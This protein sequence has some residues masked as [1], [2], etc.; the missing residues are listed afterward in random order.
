MKTYH[1]NG[2]ISEVKYIFEENSPFAIQEDLN[3]FFYPGDTLIRKL[4]LELVNLSDKFVRLFF[5]DRKLY[6]IELLTLPIGLMLGGQD[7]DVAINKDEFLNLA[8]HVL[9]HCDN[10]YKHIYIMD[11]QYLISTVQNLLQSAEYCYLQYYI[12]IAQIDCIH[13]EEKEIL[14]TSSPESM[15]L[16]FYLETFFIKL[17]SILDIIVKII[18]ELEN[19]VEVFDTITKLNSS[20]KLWGDRKKL[21]ISKQVDTIFEKCETVRIIESLRNEA[22]HNGTW[23]F[24][25][26]VFIKFKEK[27]IVE[28]YMLFPDI[29]DGRLASV[30]NRKHFFSTEKKVNDMLVLIHDDFYKRLLVTLQYINRNTNCGDRQEIT[31]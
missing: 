24:R 14:T 25:P 3:H 29:I 31:S 7:S 23:E 26:K 2:T 8:K 11:C 16:M 17:Y 28:R 5:L 20:E 12:E 19:P 27:E 10:L 18:Y 30:K 13:L 21:L 4:D 15:N 6:N 22:V 1:Q 9:P